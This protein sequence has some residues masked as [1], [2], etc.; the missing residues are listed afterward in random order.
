MPKTLSISDTNLENEPMNI[1]LVGNCQTKALAWY[2]QQINPSFD[3]K[4]IQNRAQ[5][6]S[7]W[8]TSDCFE[9]KHVPTLTKPEDAIKRLKESSLVI[10]Q[11]LS[12]KASDYFHTDLIR[13]YNPDCM[14]IT[15]SV[16]YLQPDHPDMPGLSGMIERETKHNHDI[17]AH[18]IFQEHSDR[19]NIQ[20][21]QTGDPVPNHP[22]CV[23][24]LEVMRKLCEITGWDYYT[25]EQYNQYLE[26]KY[27]F[28]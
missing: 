6:E 24:F 4:W 1:T 27:P 17:K 14:F 11:I 12:R 28:G 7:P 8:A 10:H 21:T 9:G 2:V 13:T 20:F 19:I 23:Y 22:T 18:K 25:D 5:L 15:I 16:F 3:V 26:E